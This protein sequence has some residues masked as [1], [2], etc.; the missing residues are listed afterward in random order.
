MNP[1]PNPRWPFITNIILLA[2][3]VLAVSRLEA[4]PAI[5]HSV[6]I[7]YNGLTWNTETNAQDVAELLLAQWGGYE[8]LDINPS[9][10]TRLTNAMTITIIGKSTQALDPTVAINLKLKQAQLAKDAQATAKPKSP[11][12]S[13]LATWYRFG[14]KLTAASR[15]YPKGTKVRVA[16]INSGKTVDVTINDYGPSV[17]T[18][19]DLDL[20]EPAFAQIAPLGAGKIKVKYYKI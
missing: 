5:R 7:S 9:P 4:S 2:L 17:F 3:A 6:T 20:N 15:R 1:V 14:D 16:A 8:G 11:I 12:Y 13:G 10:E 19:I 18:G